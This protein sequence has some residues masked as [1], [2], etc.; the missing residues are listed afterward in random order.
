MEKT[1]HGLALTLTECPPPP[2]PSAAVL[3]EAWQ[4][5]ETFGGI[6]LVGAVTTKQG[7]GVDGMGGA[8]YP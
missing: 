6:P 1:G 8:L 7:Q 2:H 3:E 5:L 4:T